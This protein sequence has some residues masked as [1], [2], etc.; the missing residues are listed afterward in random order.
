MEN[1]TF[2]CM[3]HDITLSLVLSEDFVSQSH[4]AITWVNHMQDL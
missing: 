1:A 2:C 3:F 4:G